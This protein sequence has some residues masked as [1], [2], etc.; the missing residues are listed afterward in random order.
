MANLAVVIITYNEE[1]HL[2]RALRSVK[3]FANEVFVVDSYST[4]KTVEIARKHGAKVTQNKFITHAKQFQW[5]LD[6][7][8]INSSW[9]MR[10]DAD[11]YVEK[12]LALKIN[13]LLDCLPSDVTGVN[14]NRKTIFLGRWIRHGGRYPLILLRIWRRGAARVEDRFMDEHIFLTHGRAVSIGGGFADDNLRD[15]TYFIDKHNRYATQEA[16]EYLISRHKLLP[17][18]SGVTARSTS[19]QTVFKRYAK[20]LA[21]KALPFEVSALGYFFYRYIIRAG[22]LDGRKGLVY[23]FLQ[24]FWYRFLVGAKAREFNLVISKLPTREDKL[25]VLS[26]LT[27]SKIQ[28]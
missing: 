3:V 15:L 27:G 16:L 9:V 13:A 28:L 18:T 22:F 7:S 17:R 20:E 24:G 11:E 6:N 8:P 25:N 26:H 4:D 21:L 19:R 2:D 1:V 14:L 12:D 10:L 5:A 23:H